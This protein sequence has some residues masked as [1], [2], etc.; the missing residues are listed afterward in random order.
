MRL[1]DKLRMRLRSLFGRK[2]ADAE[3]NDELR[4]H[5]EEPA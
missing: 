1:L 5:L 2:T 4:F 3:L